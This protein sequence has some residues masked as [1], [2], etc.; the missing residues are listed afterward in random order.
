[1]TIEGL[2]FIG[3]VVCLLVIILFNSNPRRYEEDDKYFDRLT[4]H[5]NDLKRMRGKK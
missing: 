1:M 2:I 3:A 4:Q 5:L